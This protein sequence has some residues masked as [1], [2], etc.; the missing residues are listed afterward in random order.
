ML[1]SNLSQ[2]SYQSEWDHKF[3]HF[4]ICLNAFCKIMF[5]I[6]SQMSVS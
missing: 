4:K 6:M 1:G 2:R 5:C 3:L